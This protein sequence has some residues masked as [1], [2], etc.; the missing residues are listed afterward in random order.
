MKTVE[1]YFKIYCDNHNANS[2]LELFLIEVREKIIDNLDRKYRFV[3]QKYIDVM[4]L[5]DDRWNA[6][7]DITK[8]MDK[9]LNR[10]SLSTSIE[11]YYPRLYRRWKG[12]KKNDIVW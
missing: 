11:V 3:P 1:E 4:Q 2:L 8:N 6:V 10:K 5:L 9:S 7:A 12:L